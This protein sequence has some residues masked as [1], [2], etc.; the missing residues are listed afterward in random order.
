MKFNYRIVNK[1]AWVAVFGSMLW[2]CMLWMFE[3][4]MREFSP[5][6]PDARGL[7]K[8]IVV[9]SSLS[10]CDQLD[11][12]IVA[13]CYLIWLKKKKKKTPAVAK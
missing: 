13:S 7:R 2:P 1:A 6:F 12:C 5:L 11:F 10:L 4:L 8:Y 3:M 9:L